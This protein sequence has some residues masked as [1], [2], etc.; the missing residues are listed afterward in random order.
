MG[1]GL[2]AYDR[3]GFWI[4]VEPSNRQRRSGAGVRVVAVANQKGG[5]GK[6]T[7]SV[8]LAAAL[9]QHGQKVLVIDLDPQGNASQALGVSRGTTGSDMYDVLIEGADLDSVV[10]ATGIEGLHCAPASVDLAGAEVE[11]VATEDRESQLK[12]ALSDAEKL[13]DTIVIIDCPPSLGLLT[14]NAFAA[15]DELFVP[16]QAEFYAL[17]GVS[18]LVKTLELVRNGLNPKLTI[19]LVA[20]TMVDDNDP[21]Q[22]RVAD[23]VA[24][25]FG[26]CLA[27]TRIP[28]D[29]HAN[30]APG[31][32][33]TLL[34][35]A[36]DSPAAQAY[37]ALATELLVN[38]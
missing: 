36:P 21:A 15:A 35:Y 3:P 28:R 29:P 37:R 13:D 19:G 24:G 12:Q 27:T 26:S 22:A 8:N 20:L 32:A 14:V 5:V 30:A 1:E 17:D 7:S 38:N 10:R 33:Q 4:V 25:Y 31:Q 34:Q 6:T 2:A 9:A 11:L 16:I 18:Q 23:E